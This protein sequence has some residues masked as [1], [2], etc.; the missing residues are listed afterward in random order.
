M[1]CVMA[2]KD[3]HLNDLFLDTL[4][5]IYFAEKQIL[6]ALPKMA[7]AAT[8]DKL[9]AA[10]EKHHDETEGQVERLEQIFE[11]IDKPARGKTCDAIVGILD[12]GKEIMEEYKGTEALD[13]GMLAAAQAVEHYEISRYGTLKQWAQQLG[14]KEAVRLLDETLQQEKKTD[15]ALTS[16]ADA[17]VNL[18]AA[19]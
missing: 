18:A 10:F 4:K 19:A 6:K 17:A 14:M 16:L 1:E 13:A 11:L 7:K 15:Q 5:D 12:E 3:K 2:T 9:R 8:S